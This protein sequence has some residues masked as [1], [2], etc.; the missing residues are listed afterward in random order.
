MLDTGYLILEAELEAGGSI[1]MES[2][3]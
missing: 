2:E 1:P 3:E